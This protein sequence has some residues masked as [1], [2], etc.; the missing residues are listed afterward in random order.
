M[1]NEEQMKKAQARANQCRASVRLWRAQHE[2]Y[3][4]ASSRRLLLN[5]LYHG[6]GALDTLD[7]INL[8]DDA[9]R[10]DASQ[11][12]SEAHELEKS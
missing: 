6:V 11:W 4:D 2:R 9:M 7:S 12:S 1:T 10:A 5:A 8:S 3:N